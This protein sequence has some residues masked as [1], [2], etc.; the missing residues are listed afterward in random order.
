MMPYIRISWETCI[1]RQ[2]GR[3]NLDQGSIIGYGSVSSG[4]FGENVTVAGST[5]KVIK[6]NIE[7]T[8][9]YLGFCGLDNISDSRF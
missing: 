1:D 2:T 5:A 6:E 7:W 9:D 4:Q 3:V 8:R